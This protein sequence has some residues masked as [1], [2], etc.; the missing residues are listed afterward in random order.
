MRNL[1]KLFTVTC[2]HVAKMK[3]LKKV[4]QIPHEVEHDLC[5]L[6]DLIIH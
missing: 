4:N 2:F 1:F 6:L 3:N 5:R